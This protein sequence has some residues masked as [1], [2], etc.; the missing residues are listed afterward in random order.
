MSSACARCRVRRRIPRRRRDDGGGSWQAALGG[1]CALA[2]ALLPAGP[3][4]ASRRPSSGS[5]RGPD[6]PRASACSTKSRRPPVT[7]RAVAARAVRTGA[8]TAVR[9]TCGNRRLRS[10]GRRGHRRPCDEAEHVKG[11]RAAEAWP[12]APPHATTTSTSRGASRVNVARRTATEDRH[13]VE[14]ERQGDDK[15][16]AAAGAARPRRR[17][18][19]K[20]WPRPRC[21]GLIAIER[22]PSGLAEG[23]GPALARRDTAERDRHDPRGPAPRLTERSRRALCG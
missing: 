13:E 17:R 15:D 16:G 20:Q 14:R 7:A 9:P 5:P 1:A 4:W 3:P 12:Q 18:R 2:A 19:R 21:R 8:A 11:P 23:P 6:R 22:F 10:Q